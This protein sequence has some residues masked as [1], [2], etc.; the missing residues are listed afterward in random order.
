MASDYASARKVGVEEA[1]KRSRVWLE[2]ELGCA[3]KSSNLRAHRYGR[4]EAIDLAVKNQATAQLHPEGHSGGL[5]PLGFTAAVKILLN[6]SY[7]YA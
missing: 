4:Y 7:Q 5:D 6:Q 1:E 3:C 2:S